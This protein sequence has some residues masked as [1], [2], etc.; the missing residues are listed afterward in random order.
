MSNLKCQIEHLSDR[1][2]FLCAT[3]CG[4]GLVPRAPGT[5]GSVVGLCLWLAASMAP[6]PL[7]IETLLV[8]VIA[9][10]GVWS[11]TRAERL[12]NR[13]DPP[14]VVV[15]EVVGM[16]ITF[17][18]ISPTWKSACMGFALFRLLD[19]LKPFPIC[20]LQR[21]RGGWGIMAD[22][23]AAGAVAAVVLRVLL[24]VCHC[25]FLR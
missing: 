25:G 19:I 22:D 13:S 4:A 20:R 24:H 12:M 14:A 1:I 17:I 2:A 21:L 16:L 7:T 9:V 23:V 5:A 6:W 8:V 18:G 11:G 10:I 3:A 15:D